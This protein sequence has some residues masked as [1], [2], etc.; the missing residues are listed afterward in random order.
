MSKN[1]K[2]DTN[3]ENLSLAVKIVTPTWESIKEDFDWYCTKIEETFFQ[4]DTTKKELFTLPKFEEELT[5]DV[6]NKRLFKH[7]SAVLNFMECIVQ[8]MNGNEETKPVLFVLGRNHYTIGV[9]EKLFLEMK[10]AICS[11]IKFKIGTENAKAWDTIL[12]YILINYVFEGM[13]M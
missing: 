8:F 11:V 9:N 12:Q 1:I 2:R 3:Q 6:V 13:T 4:N 5:D 7:S 10:D